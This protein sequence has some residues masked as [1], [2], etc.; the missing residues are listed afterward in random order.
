MV[1][2]V[3]RCPSCCE[4]ISVYHNMEQ[5]RGLCHYLDLS[6]T[7]CDWT[8]SFSTSKEAKPMSSDKGR[9]GRNP[10]D[11][12]IRSVIATREVGRGYTALQSLCGFMNIAPPMTEETFLQTQTSV[13]SVY[14]NV[15]EE[16]MR[17][18]VEEIKENMEEN[19]VHNTIIS[20]DGTWQKR[21][22]SSRNG[23]VSII[24]SSTG[25]CLD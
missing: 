21:G 5:K 9:G 19:E 23:V 8:S 12:N 3:G 2:V 14:V 25:K 17:S 20:T 22:F 18:A 15:A 7:K 6:C 11:V 4:K 13:K 1:V 24:S 10:H 16:N